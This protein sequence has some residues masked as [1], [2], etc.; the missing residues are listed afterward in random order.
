MTKCKHCG[1]EIHPDSSD[2]I[3]AAMALICAAFIGGNAVWTFGVHFYLLPSAD[4]WS[5]S[6]WYNALLPVVLNVGLYASAFILIAYAV[7]SKLD[8]WWLEE[9]K[10]TE[11]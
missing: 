6:L 1:E 5:I 10:V 9:K 11:K 7:L 3:A 2:S 4:G 8:E